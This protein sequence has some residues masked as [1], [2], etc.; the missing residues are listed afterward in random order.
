MAMKAV[1]PSCSMVFPFWFMVFI[2]ITL[3]VS[4]DTSL[5][6]LTIFL[7]QEFFD[8]FS[9]VSF[10]S[11]VLFNLI[12]FCWI[13]Y[14]DKGKCC[15]WLIHLIYISYTYLIPLSYPTFDFKNC[16]E[17][18]SLSESFV[19]HSWACETACGGLSSLPCKL[20]KQ[21]LPLH[22]LSYLKG[23]CLQVCFFLRFL[24]PHCFW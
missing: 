22:V 5:L 7:L 10:E 9:C 2:V 20:S 1:T 23:A 15:H 14:S 24:R 13:A 4:L 19:W 17:L 16:D 21:N 12:W 6:L 18:L 8:L 3:V 11:I